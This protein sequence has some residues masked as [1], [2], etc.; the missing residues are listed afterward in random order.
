MINSIVDADCH[1]HLLHILHHDLRIHSRFG[2]KL[3]TMTISHQII[4]RLY[5]S[6]CSQ[7]NCIALDISM[8]RCHNVNILTK[9]KQF[10]ATKDTAEWEDA[11]K[12]RSTDVHRHDFFFRLAFFRLAT[13][14]LLQTF[15]FFFRFTCLEVDDSHQF[16]SPHI[17]IA[18]HIE[19]TSR[20]CH[21]YVAFRS[22][23]WIK[24]FRRAR[25]KSCFGPGAKLA[26][27]DV[28]TVA[29][30]VVVRTWQCPMIFLSTRSD[31][32]ILN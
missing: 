14:S 28:R 30:T 5:S 4:V 1:T 31:F 24:R 25:V 18:F 16:T 19:I 8:L 11:K 17:L 26:I 20:R 9:L 15:I 3:R 6:W 22:C 27:W 2:R 10:S 21:P 29:R 23:G 32:K 7:L 12:V 13:V